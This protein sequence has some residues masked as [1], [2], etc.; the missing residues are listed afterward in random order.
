MRQ[1]SQRADA[2]GA[3]ADKRVLVQPRLQGPAT[4]FLT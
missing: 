4:Q 3:V 2:L 1:R